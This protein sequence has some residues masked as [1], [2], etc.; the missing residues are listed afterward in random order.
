[1]RQDNIL[2]VTNLRNV[3]PV[4]VFNVMLTTSLIIIIIMKDIHIDWVKKNSLLASVSS[5]TKVFS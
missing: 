5:N 2:N 1:M 4:I 3:Y